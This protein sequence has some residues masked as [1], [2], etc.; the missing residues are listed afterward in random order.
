MPGAV[1]SGAPCDTAL[2]GAAWD[3]GIANAAAW[4]VVD[5]GALE[6]RAFPPAMLCEPAGAAFLWSALEDPLP[7]RRA[8][9]PW[10]AMRRGSVFCLAALATSA[11]AQ[12]C[13]S[14]HRRR[15][16]ARALNPP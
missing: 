2:L 7:A 6:A 15:P 10:A 4:A 8:A 5:R 11:A 12:R 9:V 1:L 16:A 3:T 14:H 13:L